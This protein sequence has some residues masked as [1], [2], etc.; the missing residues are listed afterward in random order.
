VPTTEIVIPWRPGC[1]YRQRA[2]DWVLARY[3]A[4]GYRVTVAEHDDGGPWVKAEAVTPAVE[5]SAVDLI[6]IADADVWCDGLPAAI[7]AA[8]DHPWAI[9]HYAVL[10]LTPYVTEAVYA[11]LDLAEIGRHDLEQK[12]Y[13]GFRGGGIVVVPRQTYLE[14]PL[15]PRF[16]GWG[17]EDR[18]LADALTTLAGW[19]WRGRAD[20]YHLWHPPQQRASRQV[21]STASQQLGDAY[22]RALNHPERMRALIEAGRQWRTSNSSRGLS[23]RS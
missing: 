21:G 15:D 10:R 3:R 7:E 5:A 8:A 9:P 20:L 4:D 1:P 23:A 16:C 12:A 14:A 19:P 22:R 11:G 18:S 13:R 17:D 2:L 6:V